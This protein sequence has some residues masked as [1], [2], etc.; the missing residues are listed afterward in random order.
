[1]FQD[2][3]QGTLKECDYVSACIYP[4]STHQSIHPITDWMDGLV[5]GWWTVDVWDR[6]M[7]E[8]TDGCNK[9]ASEWMSERARNEWVAGWVH[10]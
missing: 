2:Q 10:E 5:D 6:W 1:M 9:K 8:R 7:D 4:P 3:G